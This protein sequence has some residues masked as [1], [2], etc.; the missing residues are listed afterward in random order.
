[1]E[2]FLHLAGSMKG[3]VTILV[4]VVLLKALMP[5]M[6]TAEL[7]RLPFLFEHFKE[8]RKS[9]QS[10][11][12]L[13]FLILH[14]SDK[15]HHNSDHAKHSKLPFGNMHHQQVNIQLWYAEVCMIIIPEF[16]NTYF[17]AV[18]TEGKL[19]SIFKPNVWQP[20]RSL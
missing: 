13:D 14:Y 4:F 5:A 16:S 19:L 10:I 7:A 6:N 9:N 8:H 2:F 3:L 20:P 1:M 15:N 17:C 18:L 12:F 11:T